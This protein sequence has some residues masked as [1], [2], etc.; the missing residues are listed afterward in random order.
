MAEA[1]SRAIT[2]M[3]AATDPALTAA[4]EAETAAEADGAATMLE[5]RD[6][7]VDAS[8]DTTEEDEEE[9]EEEEREEEESDATI[10]AVE[11]NEVSKV[12]GA[13]V[14]VDKARESVVVNE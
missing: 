14:G 7:V 2:R 13:A 1:V 3:L 8:T 5:L 9:E 10:V 12:V 11:L 4:T 6:M